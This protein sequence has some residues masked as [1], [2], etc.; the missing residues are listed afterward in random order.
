M[1]LKEE[2]EKRAI[3]TAMGMPIDVIDSTIDRFKRDSGMNNAEYETSAFLT[4]NTIKRFDIDMGTEVYATLID[5]RGKFIRGDITK[6]NTHDGYWELEGFPWS[7]PIYPFAKRPSEPIRHF[8][9]GNG[10]KVTIRKV[11]KRKPDG[12][13]GR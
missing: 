11:S 7:I 4:Y 8:D 12:F 1:T 3:F 9:I 5:P 10:W 2:L 13:P 6:L